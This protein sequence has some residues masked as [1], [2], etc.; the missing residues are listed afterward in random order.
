MRGSNIL[1]HYRKGKGTCKAY[2]HGNRILLPQCGW[3]FC[4]IITDD[5]INLTIVKSNIAAGE[6]RMMWC[7][8]FIT[9]IAKYDA[10]FLCFHLI[11][12]VISVFFHFPFWLNVLS[13]FFLVWEILILKLKNR[14]CERKKWSLLFLILL[15]SLP[16]PP[17][18]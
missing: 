3:G 9:S 11:K 8:N 17:C 7:Q 16:L 5:A 14:N 10:I 13:I 12:I 4:F 2:E 18:L 15:I 1:K 6:G